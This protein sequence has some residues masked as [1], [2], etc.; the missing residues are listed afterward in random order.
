MAGVRERRPPRRSARVPA[1]RCERPERA[2]AHGRLRRGGQQLGQQLAAPPTA[3][4]HAPRTARRPAA[5]RANGRAAPATAAMAHRPVHVVDDEQRRATLAEVVDQP[6][7]PACG[8]VHRVAAG[9]RLARSAASA[10]SASAGRPRR[11]LLPVAAG[12]QGV[13]QLPRR[14][15]R[16]LLLERAAACAQH[17][18]PVLARAAR[19]SGQEV[20]LPIPAGPSTTI[21]RPSPPRTH[22]IR[23]ASAASSASRS[24]S[25]AIGNPNPTPTAARAGKDRG[26]GHD[27]RARSGARIAGHHD[28]RLRAPAHPR[29]IRATARP[30]A[31]V[32]GRH[33]AASSTGSA[34][35][36]APAAW[37]PAADRA[38][39]CG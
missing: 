20:D 36:R 38:R 30:G 9:G 31:R 25:T 37:M 16:R 23:S 35:R 5:P 11:Q 24:S 19:G 26:R 33:R 22:A 10:R 14:A 6:H 27:A 3:H 32:G 39:R 18:R 12:A 34:W 8:G 17:D 13:E 29:G 2:R 4:R 21:T 28:Y 1:S 7:Q 15:P